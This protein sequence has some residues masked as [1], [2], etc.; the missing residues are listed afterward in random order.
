MFPYSL[1]LAPLN[2]EG[3][4]RSITIE[5]CLIREILGDRSYIVVT[6][7]ESF[8]PDGNL[9]PSVVTQVKWDRHRFTRKW[10][11]RVGVKKEETVRRTVEKK[12]VEKG[13]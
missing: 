10:M 1:I 9:D 11:R 13:N 8:E 4:R 2:I 12:A 6:E 3:A 7:A 5:I